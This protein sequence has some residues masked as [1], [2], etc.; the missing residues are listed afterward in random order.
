MSRSSQGFGNHMPRVK[1]E[2]HY[3]LTT[4]FHVA[5][6]ESYFSKGS[7]TMLPQ[8]TH[9]AIQVDKKK[10]IV[11]FDFIFHLLNYGHLVTDYTTM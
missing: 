4:N 7:K 2:D 11:Q 5:N 6:E 9:G 1:M 8:V 3:F 10:K